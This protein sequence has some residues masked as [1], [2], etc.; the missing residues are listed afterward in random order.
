MNNLSNDGRQ[1]VSFSGICPFNCNHCYTFCEGYTTDVE[2]I[3]VERIISG[4]KGNNFDIV[5]VSGHRENFIDHIEGIRLCE[6][7]YSNFHT[8]IMLTTRCVFN[9]LELRR[10]HNLNVQMRKNGQFLFFCASIPALKS[11]KKLEPSLLIPSPEERISCLKEVFDAGIF[12][13]LTVRPLCPDNYIPI[14]E[15]LEIIKRCKDFSSGVISSG[16]VVDETIL[17]RL[18]DFPSDFSYT[19][20]PLMPC[21]NNEDISVKY[22]NVNTELSILQA[23]CNTQNLPFY[24]HSLPLIKFLKESSKKHHW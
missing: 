22:V 15:P 18:P 3:S 12:T 21:L 23:Y 17:N 11:Y 24:S 9:S 13:V 19:E 6:E 2:D 20:E 5:Y 4:I 16:I 1:F 8:D 7:L 10:L 14:D